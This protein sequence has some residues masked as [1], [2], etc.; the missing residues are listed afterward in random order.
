MKTVK[1]ASQTRQENL[2]E[3]CAFF[4]LKRDAYYKYLK[5]Y[6]VRKLQEK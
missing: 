3:I 6:N 1:I 5:R 4:D 2:S